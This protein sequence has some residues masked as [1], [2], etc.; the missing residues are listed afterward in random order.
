[1]NESTIINTNSNADASVFLFFKKNQFL[2]MKWVNIAIQYYSQMYAF[3]TFN[4]PK[5]LQ[6]IKNIKL[7]TL[8]ELIWCL[9]LWQYV[10]VH[11]KLI[12]SHSFTQ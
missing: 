2:V 5:L 3:L 1:M 12:F 9:C 7:I 10:F 8:S 6:N 4:W 11:T